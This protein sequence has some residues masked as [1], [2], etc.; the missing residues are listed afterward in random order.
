MLAPVNSP[1]ELYASAQL[2]AREF[3]DADGVPSQWAHVHTRLCGD[4]RR[5]APEKAA[6]TPGVDAGAWAGTRILEFGAGAAGPIATRYFAEHGATV[7]RVE[8]ASRPDF[9][10]T[11][12]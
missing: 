4:S 11:G 1:R 9:L 2:A 10:R 6:Q 12:N 3:F 5:E 8:S 7:V